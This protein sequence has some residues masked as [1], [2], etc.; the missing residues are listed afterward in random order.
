MSNLSLRNKLLL[1]SLFPLIFTLLVLITL[2]YYV[3]QESLA[4]EVVTF[5]TKLVGERKQQIK[6]ATEIASGIVNYQLSLKDKGNV[7]QALRDIRFGS[8]GYFF[9]YDSQGKNI[10]H[11][12]MPNLEGQNKIDMT[13]PRGTKIIVGLLD[14]AKRGDGNF[15]YYYQKPNTNEQIEKI[16]FVMMVPGTDWMLGT[17]AYIDDIEAVVEDY[18]QTVTEQMAEKSLMIL[19]I[20]LVLTGATAFVIMVAAH[21]MV[22]PIKNMADNLNDIAKGEGDLTKRLSVKGEDEIAQLGRAF[23]LFVDKLQ[24]IIGDVASATAKVK[25]AA[26]AI[27]DQTKVMS[28]QLLSHNNETDQVVTAI[29]E[30][31][32][33]ASEVAQ[34]TTQ[35]AEATQAA[36]GDVANAQRCVDASLEE[37]AALMEQINHA[38]G[39]IK[40]LSEQSQKI[41]SVLSVIGG[42]AEQT[43]LLAL[44]AAIE[45]ARAG[46]QGRGFAVVADEVR[47]LASR[48]QASTLEINEMLSALHKLVSQAVKTMDES[49]QSCVRSVESSRAI[50]ESLGS[51]TSAVTAINDMST[52]IATAATEQSSV[53]EEINRNVYAIQEIV[54]ELLHSSEHAARVSQTVS[55]EGTNLGN[56]VGQFKI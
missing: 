49:Q 52:Q 22:V 45:A 32:S 8:A 9:M 55:Q 10:F 30:M 1:L 6:E 2:S 29:T 34:N 42:I 27:H 31:S 51:V 33:T 19:L 43:N 3:E 4:E 13:D 44:N 26:N 53:T 35:V 24:H 12:L 47:S 25:T 28:S 36:T 20:A 11:A 41:N 56:L 16:S 18:R 50:S 23:N 17:G 38:A 39:S 37:I 15:S 46:E 40:S 54:N 7:N 21:R 14:A 48:T 5:R